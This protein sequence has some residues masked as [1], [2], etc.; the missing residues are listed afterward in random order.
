[1]G[2][3]S[4]PKKVPKF[5]PENRPQKSKTPKVAVGVDAGSS[6]PVWKFS[7]LD[8][9]GPWCPSKCTEDGLR[10]LIER[11]ADFES[12]SWVEIKSS[13]SHTV[14]AEG[15]TKQARDRLTQRKFDDWAD[16]IDA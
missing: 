14:G 4:H 9:D 6:K 11:L 10:G 15:I 2:K 13:G 8:W 5:A 3:K 7:F 12:M 1:M 16:E